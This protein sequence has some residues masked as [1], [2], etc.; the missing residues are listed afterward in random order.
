MRTFIA[1]DVPEEIS[2]YL[3]QLQKE[4]N[5]R[6]SL[7]K[8]FHL[9]LKFLGE[10]RHIEAEKIK[11]E[12]S[13]IKFKPFKLKLNKIGFF[14]DERNIRVVWVGFKDNRDLIDLQNQVNKATQDYKEDHPFSPH[15]TLARIKF[16]RDRKAFLESLKKIQVKDLEFTVNKFKLIKSELTP[17][18]PIYTTLAE[19]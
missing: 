19:F 3:K 5:E 10:V 9:T 6:A 17:E 7:P 13:K 18:Y 12:L 2:K 4:I 1:I 15:L 8:T 14:P 11:E 16:V